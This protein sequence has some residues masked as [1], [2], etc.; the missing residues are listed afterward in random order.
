M[1]DYWGYIK[2][3]KYNCQNLIFFYKFVNNNIVLITMA[4]ENFNF[5]KKNFKDFKAEIKINIE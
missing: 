3:T 2:Y 5:S 1:N 4:A